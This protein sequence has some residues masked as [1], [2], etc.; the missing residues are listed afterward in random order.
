VLAAGLRSGCRTGCSPSQESTLVLGIDISD[1][2][3]LDPAR[4][5]TSPMT[6]SAATMRSSP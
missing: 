4:R 6:V 2:I 1:T 3:T 5:N